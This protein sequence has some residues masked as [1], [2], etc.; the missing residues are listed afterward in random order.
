MIKPKRELTTQELLADTLDELLESLRETKLVALDAEQ[1]FH[2]LVREI[3]EKGDSS[4]ASV[5]VLA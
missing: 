1:Y 5:P 4:E 3:E 2:D